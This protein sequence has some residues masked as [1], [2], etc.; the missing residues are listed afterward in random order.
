MNLDYLRPGA[1]IPI[2]AEAIRYLV[3]VAKELQAENNFL[4]DWRDTWAPYVNQL[5]Q[6]KSLSDEE[7]NQLWAESHED[8]I[9]TQQ[10]FTTQQHYFVHLILKKA[11]N[12]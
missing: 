1:T 9:A 7:I 5:R 10:G 11:S 3:D 2:T 12:K 4:K 8:G 6:T